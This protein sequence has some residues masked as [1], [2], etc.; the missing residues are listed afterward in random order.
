MLVTNGDIVQGHLE[1]GNQCQA[2][3]A[4]NRHVAAGQRLELLFDLVTIPVEIACQVPER[5]GGQ[6]R[7]HEGRRYPENL[8]QPNPS[9]S[10][11]ECSGEKPGTP[12]RAVS[13]HSTVSQ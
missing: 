1:I 7:D 3:V 8:A 5:S 4:G 12:W 2:E 11:P 9:P 10:Y 13:W 6:Q